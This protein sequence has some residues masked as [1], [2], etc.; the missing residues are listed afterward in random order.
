MQGPALSIE[1]VN[2]CPRDRAGSQDFTKDTMRRRGFCL[3]QARSA[4]CQGHSYSAE[5]KREIDTS[6]DLSFVSRGR[7]WSAGRRTGLRGRAL[8]NLRPEAD[9][10]IASEKN[11]MKQA[12]VGSDARYYFVKDTPR[13]A[14]NEITNQT[15]PFHDPRFVWS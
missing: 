14:V 15:D 13:P 1:V 12:G 4:I 10:G 11:R 7:L 3:D 5:A 8:T 9:K 2:E 6:C